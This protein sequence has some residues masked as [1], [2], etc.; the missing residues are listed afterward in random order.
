MGGSLLDAIRAQTDAEQGMIAR[1]GRLTEI[2]E[3]LERVSNDLAEID[4]VLSALRQ[5]RADL[6]QAVDGQQSVAS[7]AAESGST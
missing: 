4:A 3:G 5:Q 7:S 6:K 2:S 1:Q